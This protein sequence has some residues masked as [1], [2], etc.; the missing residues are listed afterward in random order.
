[1]D[2]YGIK[3]GRNGQVMQLVFLGIYGYFAFGYSEEPD[4]VITSN[5]EDFIKYFP[6]FDGTD[7]EGMTVDVAQRYHL[8]FLFSFYILAFVMLSNFLFRI[9]L[10][11]GLGNSLGR[12]ILELTRLSGLAM[13]LLWILAWIWRFSPSGQVAS[14]ADQSWSDEHYGTLYH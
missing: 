3:G 14:G 12:L 6:F 8:F 4:A 1:M 2:E 5:S 10:E 9:S 11:L 13:L 7:G